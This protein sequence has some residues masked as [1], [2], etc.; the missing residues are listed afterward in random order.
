MS[1]FLESKLLIPGTSTEIGISDSSGTRLSKSLTIFNI[2]YTIKR[3]INNK[4]FK[5]TRFVEFLLLTL[6]TRGRV[7]CSSY[8]YNMPY[9]MIFFIL[10]KSFQI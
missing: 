6:E 4:N 5:K 7:H 3:Y 10:L 8:F 2:F 9:V 1:S